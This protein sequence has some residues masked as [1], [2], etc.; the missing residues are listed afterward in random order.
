MVGWQ[1]GDYDFG[2]GQGV[3]CRVGGGGIGIDCGLY[4]GGYQVE[5]VYCVVSFGQV[6]GYWVIYVVQFNKC[7]MVYVR[8]FL[9]LVILRL[10]SGCVV[11]DQG[12]MKKV[13]VYVVVVLVR[14]VGCQC[15]V[16]FLLINS[17]WMFL[18]KL[19]WV[20]LCSVVMYFRW[21]MLVS[22]VL[23][24]WCCSLKVNCVELGVL[25]VSVVWV[26]CNQGLL[27]FS[28]MIVFMMVVRLMLV[29]S[30]LRVVVW[31]SSGLVVVLVVCCCNRVLSCLWLCLVFLFQCM[32]S[33]VVNIV[34]CCVFGMWMLVR[35]VQIVL[36]VLSGVLVRVRNR[37]FL[38][39]MCGSSQLLFMLGN[40]LMVIFGNV[41]FECLLIM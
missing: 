18:V 28:V 26:V 19:L 7:D 21:Q 22:D 10:V 15:G 36:L 9:G 13:W 5:Y 37:L 8:F 30:V 31:C 32:L 4:G 27:V 35:L 40:R 39:G 14:V 23:V 17:V 38:F 2:I 11:L 1:Y 16:W 25:V 20:V 6:G 33:S 41:S 3:Q 12:E 34:L 29:Q 24:V